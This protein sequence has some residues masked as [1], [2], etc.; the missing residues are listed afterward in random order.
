MEILRGFFKLLVVHHFVAVQFMSLLFGHIP[1][2]R[3][4]LVCT[5]LSGSLRKMGMCH[6]SSAAFHCAT[7]GSSGCHEY[8]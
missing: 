6:S 7:L 3:S 1:V 5:N 4:F 2:G 8:F